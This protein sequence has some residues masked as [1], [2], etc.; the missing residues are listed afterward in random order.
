MSREQVQALAD[1][2]GAVLAGG[3]PSGP[4]LRR[5]AETCRGVSR[6]VPGLAPLADALG[7]LAAGRTERPRALLDV[8]LLARPLRAALSG[9]G[10]AGAMES[11]PP[12]G[13]WSST[14]AAGEAA[15]V[16]KA[17]R[18][19]GWDR[20]NLVQDVVRRHADLRLAGPL[21]RGLADA[22]AEDA[23]FLAGEVLP[24][25]GPALLPDLWPPPDG[26]DAR[27]GGRFLLAVCRLDATFGAR[28]CREKLREGDGGWRKPALW[29]LTVAAPK[30]ARRVALDW[31]AHENARK[32]REAAWDCLHE[33]PPP[34]ASALPVLAAAFEKDAYYMATHVLARMGRRAVRTLMELLRSKKWAVRERAA[35]ALG[36]I[37]PG[38]AAA[39]P[40]LTEA[41]RDEAL[42]VAGTAVHALACI[43]PAARA[44]VPRLLELLADRRADDALRF[45]AAEA[46]PEIAGDDPA[47]VSAL[48]A[49]L[50]DGDVQG[51][52]L[53]SLGRIGP[54]AKGAVPKLIAL[55]EGAGSH[56]H[57]RRDVIEVLGKIGP[58]AKAAMPLLERALRAREV[59]VRYAAAVAL[60]LMGPSGRAA[61]PVLVE[62]LQDSADAWWWE[63]EGED[64]LRALEC[65]GRAAGPAL[66]ALEEALAAEDDDERR[67]LYR[68]TIARI[69]RDA[70]GRRG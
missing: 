36:H 41:T 28:R 51:A 63:M 4:R 24:L 53:E 21:L 54:A 49:A 22:S 1:E 33:V 65:L 8:I 45:S 29:G 38:A 56:W 37:G 60:G 17:V 39:V 55:Y 32:L 15:T 67:R 52:V 64:A 69:R 10:V 57:L 16:A 12:S 20:R 58:A 13:P 6:Q 19:L 18:R 23:G 34:D 50:G 48:V 26:A 44:A 35:E 27:Q 25:F 14:A 43:G 11:L 9:S 62:A 42:A 70:R 47:V 3:A 40:A 31:L 7:R 2:V 30:E 66:P 5:A 59:R 46:L 61:V 68:R